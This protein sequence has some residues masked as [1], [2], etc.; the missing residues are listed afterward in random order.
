MCVFRNHFG[1]KRFG[2]HFIASQLSINLSEIDL[3][4][5][6][7]VNTFHCQERSFSQSNPVGRRRSDLDQETLS[8]QRQE[9]S[10]H[11]IIIRTVSLYGDSSLFCYS[12]RSK[13]NHC[14]FP[15]WYGIY[16]QHLWK[17]GYY[18]LSIEGKTVTSKASSFGVLR[19]PPLG[20][21]TGAL[22]T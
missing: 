9:K 19:K 13:I 14:Q 21:E 2:L 12:R 15:S 18:P 4:Q 7:K 6:I 22:Y 17:S 16:R 1:P 11:V 10:V 5:S 3:Y 8:C 20:K